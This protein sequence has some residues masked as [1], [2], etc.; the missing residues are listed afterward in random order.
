MGWTTEVRFP[1]GARYFF[2][3][4]H[5]VLTY[6]DAHPASDPVDTGDSFPGGKAAGA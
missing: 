4:V 3:V 1:V 6:F 5:S 2:S